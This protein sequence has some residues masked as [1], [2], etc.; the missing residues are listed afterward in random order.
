VVHFRLAAFVTALATVL[1][2]GAHAQTFPSKALK[3]V[4]PFTAG[5]VMDLLGRQVA[6]ALSEE[7]GQPAVVENIAGAA[8]GI[9]VANVKKADPDGHTLIL[10][11]PG[12][13]I[14]PIFD[15]EATFNLQRDL[16]V[17]SILVGFPLVLGVNAAIPAK[18][19]SELI[20]LLRSRPGEFNFSTPGV[21]TTVHMTSELF[22]AETGVDIVHVPYRGG[23]A[24]MTDLLAGR[25]HMVFLSATIWRPYFEEA[26][27]A[28]WFR[29]VL[30]VPRYCLTCRLLPNPAIP[31]PRQCSGQLCLLPKARRRPL[32]RG[33]SKR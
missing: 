21:G 8:G 9:A 27:H 2:A 5:G 19:L 28:G 25:V 29:P 14:T 12:M 24:S 31:K 17:V 18:N 4:V 32:S 30:D 10:A 11:E 33:S 15:P 16:E 20:S 7:L 23:T 6:Q 3:V 13:V 1:C 26:G 22:K